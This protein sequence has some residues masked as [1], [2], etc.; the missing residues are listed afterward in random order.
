[1]GRRRCRGRRSPVGGF[2][3]RKQVL[4]TTIG[5]IG[6]GNIGGAL[7]QHVIAVKHDVRV[8]NSRRPETLTEL[9][10]TLGP[11]AHAV[12]ASEAARLGDIV[13]VTVPLKDCRDVPTEGMDGKVV[14][15]TNNYYPTRDGQ[16]AELES[17][18]TTS[19]ALLAA[20]LPTARVVMAFDRIAAPRLVADGK[21]AGTPGRTAIPI[22][23]DDDAAKQVVADLSDSIGD[24]VDIGRLAT[25]ALFEPGTALY[26]PDV[27]ADSIRTVPSATS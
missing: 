15:D 13:V 4:T 24:A 7:A 20:H 9:V 1:M 25:G 22:A 10:A 2:Q 12:T 6:A 8:S 17:G 21:A 18:S 26:V 23:G 5:L 11:R 3:S 14:V 16:F 27:T 19:S